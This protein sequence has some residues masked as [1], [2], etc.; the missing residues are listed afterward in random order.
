MLYKT[1]KKIS[2]ILA[3]VVCQEKRLKLS[4]THTAQK[5]YMLAKERG[6]LGLAFPPAVSTLVRMRNC[7]F[8]GIST[9]YS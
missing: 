1:L 6:P 5:Q 9:H 7:L 3:R 8:V 4:T 2:Y